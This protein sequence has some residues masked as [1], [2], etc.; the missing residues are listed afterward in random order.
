MKRLFDLFWAS[1]GL[2][3]LWIAFIIIGLIIKLEDR[4]P[5]FFRQQRVGRRGLPFRIWKFRTMVVD[6]EQRGSTLTVGRDPR[7]TRVGHWLRATKIDELPQLINVWV[8]DM[9]LVG[10][11][12]EVQRYVDLYAKD[13]RRV[14]E[15]KPGITSL[16][17]L[18]FRKESELLATSDDP[19]RTYVDEV[20]PEKIR[21]NLEYAARAS[22]WGDFQVILM[23]LGFW[24]R[25]NI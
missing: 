7:I 16:A 12:P 9:S 3:L 13:Q 10:P 5:I 24:P 15:L 22:L 6:A 25:R 1:V 14:L 23:T 18:K 21:I 4:G 17:S 2:L 20:L 19:D 8:G 11:R